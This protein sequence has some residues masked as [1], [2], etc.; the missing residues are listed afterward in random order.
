[1]KLIL[2]IKNDKQHEIEIDDSIYSMLIEYG[3]AK[4]IS[5]EKILEI[6]CIEYAKKAE[7]E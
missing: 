5:I 2:D 3:K 6:I 1:M 7:N 4:G